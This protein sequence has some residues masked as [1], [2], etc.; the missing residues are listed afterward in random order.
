[1]KKYAMAAVV[2]AVAVLFTG[3]SFAM[4][5]TCDTEGQ[6]SEKASSSAPVKVNNTYCP[7]SGEKIAMENA[8]TVEYNGKEYNLC[9]PACIKPFKAD[10]EKYISEMKQE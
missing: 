3:Y 10:P 8:S 5:G 9:C 7:V 4:C 1:M 6:K 2:V